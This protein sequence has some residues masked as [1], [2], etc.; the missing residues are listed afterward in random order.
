MDP[1]DG[2]VEFFESTLV[3][4]TVILLGAA[5]AVA[6]LFQLALPSSVQIIATILL[7]L[8][9]IY[10][11]FMVL[12][13][14]LSGGRKVTA[15]DVYRYMANRYGVGYRSIE[16]ECIIDEDGSGELKR[17]VHVEAHSQLA[18]LDTF[19]VVRE[20]PPP[21]KTWDLDLVDVRSL[22]TGR[23]VSM[24]LKILKD[25][26]LSGLIAIAPPLDL[27]EQVVYEMTEK[28]PLGLFAVNLTKPELEQ[29]KTPYDY[30]AWTI[31]R[32]TRNLALMIHIPRDIKP[33][34]FR[35]EVR[36]ATPAPGIPSAEIQYEEQKRLEKPQLKEPMRGQFALELDV[37]CPMVG[38]MYILRWDPL[39]TAS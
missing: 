29:R 18:E 37:D 17:T 27:G 30:V 25:G 1:R 20:E 5:A 39:E 16:V 35:T 13:T 38:L 31:N 34:A 21:G 15:E 7:V 33:R 19:L 32:P 9:G 4:T 23:D 2:I 3:K 24:K 14:A 8:A 26:K 36:R 28:L 22:T 12:R 11:L 10:V 6:K